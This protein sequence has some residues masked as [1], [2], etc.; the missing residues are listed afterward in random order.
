[1]EP[2]IEITNLQKCQILLY[3][4]GITIKYIKENIQAID[5][6]P[7]TKP[8]IHMTLAVSLE[9]GLLQTGA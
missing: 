6:W 1:M 8:F 3:I 5:G 4:N 9:F 2:H 7:F